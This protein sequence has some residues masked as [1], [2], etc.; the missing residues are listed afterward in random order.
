MEISINRLDRIMTYAGGVPI[1]F[2]VEDLNKILGPQDIGHHIYTSR[3]A[4]SFADFAHHHGVRSICRR[5]DLTND[6]CALPFRS[7]LLNLQVRILHTILQYIVTPRKGH[8]D[9]VTRLDVWLLDSLR[10]RRTINLGYVILRHMLSTPGVNNRL[11]PYGS[12]ISK[13]LLHFQVL[14]RDSI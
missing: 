14:I 1:E 13:I 5:R 6:I 12:I 7:Q 3:K 2:D 10:E 4:L 8:S 11:L 9:E